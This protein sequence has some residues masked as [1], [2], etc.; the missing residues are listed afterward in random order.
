[1]SEQRKQV[2]IYSAILCGRRKGPGGHGVVL[3]YKEHR[4][5]LKGGFRR[6][7]R[8]QMAL[9]SIVL[10][11]EA[12]KMPCEVTVYTNSEDIV[13]IMSSTDSLMR[14]LWERG[15]HIE[16][17]QRLAT[18]CQEHDVTFE[19]TRKCTDASDLRQCQDL[20]REAVQTIEKMYAVAD[21]A[22]APVASPRR[23]YDD[24]E[25]GMEPGLPPPIFDHDPRDSVAGLPKCP[26][27][28]PLYR[29]C[30]ICDPEGFREAYGR[31]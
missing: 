28:I 16:L 19:T 23:R 12:L 1:M 24:D 27:G 2:S 17:W 22:T 11:L 26:H 14:V 6:T 15:A 30:A 29:K 5:K 9:V 20:A 13:D 31:G 4:K 10:G 3:R 18:A 8:L 21:S 7:T 25:V